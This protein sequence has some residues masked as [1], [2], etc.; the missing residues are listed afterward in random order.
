[1]GPLLFALALACITPKKQGQAQ[2]HYELGSAYL[3]ERN[4]EGAITELR[5]AVK[6]DRRNYGAWE[7]L[8][9]AYMSRGASDEALRAFEHAL[10]YQPDSA[11]ILN[12]YGL[13]LMS[14]DEPEAAI[15]A[16]EHALGDLTYRKPALVLNNLGFALFQAGRYDEA[17]RRLDE[18]VTRAPNLCQARFH[19]GLV[20]KAKGNLEN[21]LDDLDVVIQQCGDEAPGAYFHAAEVLMAQGNRVAA[22]TYLQNVLRLVPD[23]PKLRDAAKALLAEAED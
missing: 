12:N 14:R 21:A 18:A 15:A 11:Q 1:M 4:P 10:R 8:A 3:E 7:K 16:F 13:L 5:I 23:D 17:L 19:R 6:L 20:W 22:E 2:A 9:L